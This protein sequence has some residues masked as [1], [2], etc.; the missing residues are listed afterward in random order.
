MITRH[1]CFPSPIIIFRGIFRG[2]FENSIDCYILVRRNF[3]KKG[4]KI[5]KHLESPPSS[6]KK[7]ESKIFEKYPLDITWPNLS[8]PWLPIEGKG[9]G[10]SGSAR[11]HSSKEREG[12]GGNSRIAVNEDNWICMETGKPFNRNLASS[13]T[14]QPSLAY[15]NLRHRDQRR[16]RANFQPQV[17]LTLRRKSTKRR[18][19]S[20]RGDERKEDR[21]WNSKGWSSFCQWNFRANLP[22]CWKLSTATPLYSSI[23]REESSLKF[24]VDRTTRRLG[25]RDNDFVN[26]I[27]EF[28]FDRLV[29]FFFPILPKEGFGFDG[30]KGG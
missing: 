1:R 15:S 12:G 9:C 7:R 24:K 19:N 25:T 8:R 16:R 18:W 30:S 26:S 21:M 5:E 22:K 13:S 28:I 2:K 14:F 4:A 6:V 10:T 23:S 20:W 3:R 11:S 27:E 29:P 17:S